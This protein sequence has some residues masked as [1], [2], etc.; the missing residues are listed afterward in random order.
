MVNHTDMEIIILIACG[1]FLG[2]VFS[3]VVFSILQ[4]ALGDAEDE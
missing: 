1:V 4:I 2:V 3:E